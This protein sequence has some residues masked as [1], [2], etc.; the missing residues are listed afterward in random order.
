MVTYRLDTNEKVDERV[1][2]GEEMRE[3]RKKDGK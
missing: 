1:L 2:T 3:A